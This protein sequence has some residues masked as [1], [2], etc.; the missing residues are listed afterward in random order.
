M[1]NIIKKIVLQI[2]VSLALSSVALSHQCSENCYTCNG[3]KKCFNCYRRKV[4]QN[5]AP[6]KSSCSPDPLPDSDPC[7]VYTTMSE[8]QVCKV[9]WALELIAGDN[10]GCVKGTVQNCLEEENVRGE[11]FC[12]SCLGGY[13]TLDRSA[14]IPASQVKNPIPN[15]K[16]G[17]IG[18]YGGTSPIC[19]LCPARYTTDLFKCYKT[20]PSMEGCIYAFKGICTK[21]DVKNGYF[22]RDQHRCSKDKSS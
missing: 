6:G 8:C 21:C 14:C 2:L 10:G 17:G 20:P 22:M 16:A 9:G 12:Y 1:A 5:G 13:P 11:P 7:L 15:C 4:L 19:T 3:P 18:P